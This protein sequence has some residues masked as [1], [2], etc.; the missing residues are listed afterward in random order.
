MM[1]SDLI[2]PAG[3]LKCIRADMKL[4]MNLMKN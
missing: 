3:Y 4:R 1:E 2:F